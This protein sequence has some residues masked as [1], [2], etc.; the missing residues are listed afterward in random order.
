MCDKL[1]ASTGDAVLEA[2][3]QSAVYWLKA[4]GDDRVLAAGACKSAGDAIRQSAI[5]VGCMI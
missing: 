4:E 1:P 5:N 3:T 2:C